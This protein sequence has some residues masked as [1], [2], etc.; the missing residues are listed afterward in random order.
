[1]EPTQ[2]SGNGSKLVVIGFYLLI[3]RML[4]ARQPKLDKMIRYHPLFL[5]KMP[6]KGDKIHFFFGKDNAKKRRGLCFD[7]KRASAAE[8]DEDTDGADD[9]FISLVFNP[10]SSQVTANE[11]VAFCRY[12]MRLA[13]GENR[14]QIEFQCKRAK[15]S[16][17]SQ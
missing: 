9:N 13:A 5:P 4:G 8:E 14:T 10:T 17:P 7:V 2:E 11:V 3:F 1:M 15:K 6:K 12:L 16:R